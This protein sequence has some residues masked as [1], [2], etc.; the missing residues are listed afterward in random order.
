MKGDKGKGG[1]ETS[2][3]TDEGDKKKGEERVF[4]EACKTNILMII[5][6]EHKSNIFDQIKK[7]VGVKPFS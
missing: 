5:F 4:V 7:N 2:Q 1:E 6:V 3:R